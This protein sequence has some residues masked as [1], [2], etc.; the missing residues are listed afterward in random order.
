MNVLQIQRMRVTSTQIAMMMMV[1]TLVR[2]KMVG[3][4]MA[5]FA[6]VSDP[7]CA[8]LAS[9]WQPLLCIYGLLNPEVSVLDI[10]SIKYSTWCTS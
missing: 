2:A 5:F 10:V 3:R 7:Q 9:Y 1:L 8:F 6:L 4:G